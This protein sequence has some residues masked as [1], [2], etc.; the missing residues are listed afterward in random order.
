MTV[1]SRR[2]MPSLDVCTLPHVWRVKSLLWLPGS[3]TLANSAC[4]CWRSER[5]GPRLWH[6]S[7]SMRGEGS[8]RF[9]W[10][11]HPLRP[12]CRQQ[13][14]PS[15]VNRR[16]FR[17]SA[18]SADTIAACAAEMN[19]F[20][21]TSEL[22]ETKAF[23]GSFVKEV[24]VRPGRAATVYSIPTPDDSPI[25]GADAAKIT[26]SGRVMNSVRHGGL[27]VQIQTGVS[28]GDRAAPDLDRSQPYAPGCVRG[29]A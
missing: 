19:E 2:E 6:R 10:T 14:I 4:T 25:G 28:A 11:L 18:D 22:T 21:K 12:W 16:Q 3:P 26:L 20:L 13:R 7:R 9:E 8:P 27:A 29:S 24:M 17:D 15:A 5:R 23:V 1:P